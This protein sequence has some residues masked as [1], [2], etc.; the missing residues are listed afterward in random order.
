MVHSLQEH[1]SNRLLKHIVRC[2]LRLADNARARDALR[3][4]LPE[5]LRNNTAFGSLLKD[6]VTTARWLNQLLY[7]LNESSSSNSPASTPPP[8]GSSG[9][10]LLPGSSGA[11]QS[12]SG[13]NP[14]TQTPSSRR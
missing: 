11:Q 2:Y 4:C 5:S 8:T 1:P 6:D 10:S 3:Q 12:L 7:V 9:A 14:L 13:G